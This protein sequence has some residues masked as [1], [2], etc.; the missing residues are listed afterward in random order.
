MARHGGA[1]DIVDLR[2]LFPFDE[3][4]I[5]AAVRET[6]RVVVVTEEGD[7]TSFGRH[8]HSWIFEHHFEDLDLPAAF[9]SAKGVPAVPYNGPEEKAFYPTAKDVEA[10]LTRF[11]TA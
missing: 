2:T 10:V 8:L 1:F 5:S 11:A 9:I 4:A 6:N 3:A 7:H